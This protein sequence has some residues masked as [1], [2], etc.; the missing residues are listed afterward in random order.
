MVGGRPAWRFGSDRLESPGLDP[1]RDEI[2][3]E[4]PGE[5]AV[6]IHDRAILSTLLL[7]WWVGQE[8]GSLLPNGD[9]RGPV[10]PRP[11]LERPCSLRAGTSRRAS[12]CAAIESRSRRAPGLRQSSRS[13][14]ALDA[15]RPLDGRGAQSR[16]R[17][18]AVGQLHE[19]IGSSPSPR[20][21][22]DV[23]RVARNRRDHRRGLRRGLTARARRAGAGGIMEGDRRWPAGGVRDQVRYQLADMGRS[24]QPSAA[25]RRHPVAATGP[26]GPGRETADGHEHADQSSEP[27]VRSSK[28]RLLHTTIR[29]REGPVTGATNQNSIPWPAR[30][31]GAGLPGRVAMSEGGSGL[32]AP[33]A[34]RDGRRPIRSGPPRPVRF[35]STF[36]TARTSDL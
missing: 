12:V 6:R 32:P 10:P 8:K 28:Q 25:V 11:S 13:S 16:M 36:H 23:H 30:F 14:S 34:A 19:R 26:G 27:A 7:R 21:S 15:W 2:G 3:E 31:Q 5:V 20:E 18:G 24:W 1:G 33:S 17:R 4:T 35:S 9:G 22:C 29:T